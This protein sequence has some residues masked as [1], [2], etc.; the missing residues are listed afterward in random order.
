MDGL[1]AHVHFGVSTAEQS[2]AGV[3][4]WYWLFG[5]RGEVKGTM[6]IC[7]AFV[8][9]LGEIC[10][11]KAYKLRNWSRRRHWPEP[12]SIAFHIGSMHQVPT[13]SLI[14]CCLIVAF[15]Y[16]LCRLFR[17]EWTDIGT[18]LIDCCIAWFVYASS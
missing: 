6:S 15:G 16:S 3:T 12:V 13:G 18:R 17:M 14:S 5:Q 7:T 4:F 9:C 10:D 2:R 8:V 1:A 11:F